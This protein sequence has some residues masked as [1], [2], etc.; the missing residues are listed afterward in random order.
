MALVR[1]LEPEVMDSEEEAKDYDAMDHAVV[2]ARFCVD[3]L[4]LDPSLDRV[5]DVGTGT[6][7]IPIELVR[8]APAA[9]VVGVDLADAMLRLAEDN[10][11][12]AGAGDAISLERADAKSLPYAAGSFTAVVS[13]TILHHIPDAEAALR[14]MLRVLGRGGLLFVRDLVRPED[15]AAVAQLVETYALGQNE[16]QRA[17]FEASLRA[18]FTLAEV[19]EM[20]RR[21]GV[22][23]GAVRMTSDRHW[24][25]SYR[26]LE[27]S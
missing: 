7:Q 17:L 21:L 16:R 12:A 13:N 22:P 11:I 19:R 24:T 18:A 9:R 20:A 23:E 2:N 4:A 3:V 5:L 1:V 25:L 8:R 15:D 27:A 14:E 6:A 10:V 26:K